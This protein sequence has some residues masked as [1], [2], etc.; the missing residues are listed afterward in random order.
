VKS[1]ESG[2]LFQAGIAVAPDV[3]ER[4]LMAFIDEEAVHCDKHAV[5]SYVFDEHIDLRAGGNASC[6][7]GRTD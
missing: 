7:F 2:D 5:F 6:G 3:F 1:L 4:F